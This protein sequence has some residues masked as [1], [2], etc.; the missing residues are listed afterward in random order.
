[1]TKQHRQLFIPEKV[2]EFNNRVTKEIEL[3]IQPR[4]GVRPEIQP[5]RG[6]RP[7]HFTIDDYEKIIVEVD[8]I[9]KWIEDTNQYHLPFHNYAGPGTHVQNQVLS[10]KLPVTGIDAA[11]LVH[12]IEY[13][14]GV[15]QTT[16]DNQMWV[17]LIKEYPFNPAIAS[18]T[19]L[20]FLA[21][22]LV[23][24]DIK[25][26]ER[27]GLKLYNVVKKTG[28]L[29][30]YNSK[31][32]E[33]YFW[34]LSKKFND[35]DH[36]KHKRNLQD[37]KTEVIVTNYSPIKH[38]APKII[39]KPLLKPMKPENIVTN[40]KPIVHYAPKPIIKPKPKFSPVIQGPI[41]EIVHH[42]T[43]PIVKPK[44]ELAPTKQGPMQE[45]V[46]YTPEP[47]TRPLT[48][49]EFAPTKQGPMQ[50]LVHYAPKPITRPPTKSNYQ[51]PPPKQGG[52][53]WNR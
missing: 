17:N 10:G 4:R 50:E 9:E 5:R 18:T 13:L 42:A 52:I 39:K 3:D 7:K 8:D 41:Q 2:G 23:G 35:I 36:K 37:K 38:Y 53:I 20:A 12:D 16:A 21:K 46:H 45:L 29:D 14:A 48:K 1:L 25:T 47:I 27:L 49:S 40:Y 22:D 24:Y 33:D 32:N 31:F 26:N 51:Q 15:P 6:V 44:S 34:E 19:K 28:M 43:K 30:G 11:A